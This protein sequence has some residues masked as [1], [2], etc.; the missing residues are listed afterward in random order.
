MALTQEKLEKMRQIEA[1]IK[2]KYN[3]DQSLPPIEEA[4]EKY[5]SRP[6]ETIRDVKEFGQSIKERVI[7]MGESI[8]ETKDRVR[9]GEQTSGRAVLQTLGKGAGFASGVLGDVAIGAGK[10]LL[11]EN[12]EQ[13]VAE[14]AQQ[15]GEKITEIPFVQE[16]IEAYQWLKENDPVVASDVEAA[17]GTLSAITDALGGRAVGGAKLPS[18]GKPKIAIPTISAKP[19]K[20]TGRA[21]SEF[22]ATQF[23][24]LSPRSLKTI[25]DSPEAFTKALD[26]GINRS[27]ISAQLLDQVD[28]KISQL[29]QTGRVYKPIR[30]ATGVVELPETFVKDKL[31]DLGFEVTDDLN[32]V[33]TTKSVTRN[34]AD[35]NAI[36][37]FVNDWANRGK[38]DYAEFLNMRSD[39][40]GL[41]D[42]GKISGKTKA[43][44]TIAKSLRRDLNKYRD[45]IP[46]LEKLDKEFGSLANDLK[47]IKRKLYNRDGSLKDDV[48]NKLFRESR[49]DSKLF[50]DLKKIDPSIE[51]KIN[52][53]RAL[54]DVNYATGQK[55]GAYFRSAVLTAGAGASLATGN[56]PLAVLSILVSTPQIS[57]RALAWM[58]KKGLLPRNITTTISNSFKGGS[59]LTGE[60]KNYLET[61]IQSMGESD[62]KQMIKELGGA[63]V[64]AIPSS[65]ME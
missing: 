27:T 29:S 13:V 4:K 46:G 50:D 26:A 11:G 20:A 41:A 62:L 9:A 40:S 21:A 25:I 58:S 39:L 49:K 22:V 60:A 63:G 30:E 51:D 3:V 18:I 32:V 19:I 2:R 33:G 55:A 65:Q 14:K 56:I 17:L 47:E 54:E 6:A 37:T 43:S 57:S 42:F 28:N 36:Q 8:A 1:N 53:V 10:L 34:K 23:T 35:I 16:N 38:L 7:G 24:G 31:K 15:I 64:T 59:K 52:I 12:A 61:A 48:A 5:R 45:Q 44:E